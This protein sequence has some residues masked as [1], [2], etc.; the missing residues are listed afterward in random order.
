MARTASAALS[1]LRPDARSFVLTRSGFA[2]IQ[3]HAAVWTGDNTASWEHLRMSLPMLCNLGLSGIPFVGADIGGFWMDAT[4]ELYARWIQAGVLYPMM[5]GHS[6]RDARPN[7]PWAFGDEVEAGDPVCLLESMKMEIPV[8]SEERGT[9]SAI[10]VT[11]GDV[12]QEG[13]VLVELTAS[14]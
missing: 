7:E 6:H 13:D 1:R 4:P 14:R 3:R 10:K 9:V 8:L 11:P 12:V 2:G 5:R